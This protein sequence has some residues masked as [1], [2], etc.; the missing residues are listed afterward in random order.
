MKHLKRFKFIDLFAGIGGM[1]LAVQDVFPNSACVLACE[2]DRIAR[3][4]YN[5]NFNCG[6]QALR[7]EIIFPDINDLDIDDIPEYNMLLA[8]FSC[9][10]FS[11][12][13]KKQ[14]MNDVEN[15]NHFEKIFEIIEKTTPDCF[16]L[17]N[18]PAFLTM[19]HGEY[20]EL[21]RKKCTD[22]KYHCDIIKVCSSN[23]S[24]QKRQ[25]VY[26]I[27]IK[28][29]TDNL[30]F[31]EHPSLG[32]NQSKGPFLKDILE[33]NVDSKYTISNRF[34]AGM[35]K[36]KIEQIKAGRGFSYSLV[37]NE[38]PKTKT[39]T[40]R[41]GNGS[42][43]FVEQEGKNPR[44]FTPRECARLQGFPEDFDIVV[45]HNQAYKQFGNAVTVPVVAYVLRRFILSRM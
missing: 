41:Y 14:G 25:R 13:G 6:K 28:S 34:Y 20:Y 18:V 29:S 16:I 9:K 27:G 26:M 5:H 21:L 22:L 1:R 31:I 15:G 2:K 42:C 24:A 44:K 39:I 23:F 12:V 36:H 33:Q 17:E 4:T 19:N 7:N 30:R 38:T 10:P 37:N 32:K 35:N 40:A 45:T 11:N 43:D 8:G 3:K